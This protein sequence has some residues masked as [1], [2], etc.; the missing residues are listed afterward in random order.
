MPTGKCT[1][2]ATT[3]VTGPSASRAHKPNLDKLIKML[4]KIHAKKTQPTSD[5]MYPNLYLINF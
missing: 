3:Y 5:A 2:Y 4:Y 1:T